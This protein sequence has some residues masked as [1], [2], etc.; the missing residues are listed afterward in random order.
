[1]GFAVI[2][3]AHITQQGPQHASSAVHACVHEL[4]LVV[5][6]G[7][8][9]HISSLRY[10]PRTVALRGTRCIH[11]YIHDQ[12]TSL[13]APNAT[14]QLPCLFV[15]GQIS[16]SVLPV[17]SVISSH[18]VMLVLLPINTCRLAYSLTELDLSNN[19]GITGF[20]PPQM[21]L[22][23]RLQELKITNTNMS[24]AGIIKAYVSAARLP[25]W[26][27]SSG[28]ASYCPQSRMFLSISHCGPQSAM[29]PFANRHNN[30]CKY[31]T[32]SP[33]C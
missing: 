12:L 14:L 4:S 17:A 13:Q 22:V 33:G 30:G 31:H 29:V 1:M 8:R 15:V 3:A 16:L 27:A 24:C 28:T 26:C 10:L 18:C 2:Q 5:G 32:H 6:N 9:G 20:L 25:R 19:T 11:P 23:P 21:G 7:P